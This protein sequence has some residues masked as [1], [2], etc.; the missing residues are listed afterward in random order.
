ME[1]NFTKKNENIYVCKNC[2]FKTNKKT[3]Y[4][5][6]LSTR[7]HINR[8]VETNMEIVE[9]KKTN[10]E[11][12][13]KKCEKKYKTKSGLWKHEKYCNYNKEEQ[14][15]ECGENKDEMK[16]LVL[17]LISENQEFK[18]TVLQE[19][20]KTITEMIPKMGNNNNNNLEQE[21]NINIFLDEKCK[22]ALTM[23]EIIDKIEVSMK[24]LL[25]TK[26][27]GQVEGKI[28]TFII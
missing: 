11:Y 6:H 1:I 10:N 27:K 2:D 12:I 18:N 9:I 26:E 20:R 7:K 13:C 8:H 15:I 28:H 16:Q 24:N 4:N 25:T 14:I 3:D 22:D 21:F 23:D 19:L 17:K 5:R